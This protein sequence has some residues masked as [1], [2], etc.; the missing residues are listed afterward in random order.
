MRTI[1]HTTIVMTRDYLQ[2][3]H[4]IIETG[5]WITD[6]VSK[7]LREFDST[8]PQYNVLRIL[9]ERNNKPTTV[10]EIQNQMVQRSSN[11]T[12][13]IDRLLSKG[14]VERKECPANRRK[15][16][17]TLTKEGKQFLTKLDRKVMTFHS[18]MSNKLSDQELKQL[19]NLILKLK[20]NNNEKDISHRRK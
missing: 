10:C 7:E 11:V 16:D 1:V 6:Q 17:I 19:R 4:Q 2:A 13:I 9:S 18:P 15:M 3:V 20:G 8:E 5:H 12:R 14:L